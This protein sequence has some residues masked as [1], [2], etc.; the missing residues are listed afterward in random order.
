[1]EL[2]DSKHALVAYALVDI[3]DARDL[4]VPRIVR[5]SSFEEAQRVFEKSAANGMALL[6]SDEFSPGLKSYDTLAPILEML[7]DES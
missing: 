7:E 3:T 1:M 2:M 6:G 5:V 4:P